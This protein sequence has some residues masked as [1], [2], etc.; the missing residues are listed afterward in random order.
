MKYYKNRH[1]FHIT[2]VILYVQISHEGVKA[3]CFLDNSLLRIS[4]RDRRLERDFYS[5]RKESRRR[6][7]ERELE[8]Y[9]RTNS[10]IFFYVLERES[11]IVELLQLFLRRIVTTI[12]VSG[13][14]FLKNLVNKRKVRFLFRQRKTDEERERERIF[15]YEI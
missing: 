2:R 8:E 12:F 15:S 9:L 7:R 5:S 13:R 3:H 4:L 10:K 11:E 14:F 6:E 1:T